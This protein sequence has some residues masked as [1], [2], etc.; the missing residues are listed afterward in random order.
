ML[1]EGTKTPLET[2]IILLRVLV[3]DKVFV[4][5]VNGVVG[6][7]HELVVLVYFTCVGLA[8]KS[9]KPFLEN[10]HPHWLVA[11]DQDVDSQIELVPVD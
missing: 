2:K 9:G 1:A 6:Q 5:F 8:C 7:V 4:L 10:I 11:C 3:L